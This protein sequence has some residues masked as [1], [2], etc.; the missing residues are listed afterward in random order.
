MCTMVGA[1][2]AAAPPVVILNFL[3]DQIAHHRDR[4]PRLGEGA[5]TFAVVRKDGVIDTWTIYIRA[6][7]VV[8]ERGAA[9]FPQY[10]GKLA[11]I[12]ADDSQLDALTRSGDLSG[13]EADGDKDLLRAIAPCFGDP[14]D[15]IRLRSKK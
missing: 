4:S 13:I 14:V 15:P 8:L 2:A 7:E 3:R 5:L 6:D 1:P 12:Y 10:K 9:P 11:T